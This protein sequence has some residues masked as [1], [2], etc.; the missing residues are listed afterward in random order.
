MLTTPT[1]TY[2]GVVFSTTSV[3]GDSPLNPYGN[4]LSLASSVGDADFQF[5]RVEVRLRASV[6][7]R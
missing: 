3:G 2:T 7:Y 5:K 6:S 4:R 1:R